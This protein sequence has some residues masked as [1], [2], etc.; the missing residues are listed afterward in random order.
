MLKGLSKPIK[1][2]SFEFTPEHTNSTIECIKLLSK[3]G[4]PNFNYILGEETSFILSKWVSA[5]EIINIIHEIQINNKTVN[6]DIY[7]RF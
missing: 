2:L 3:L 5:S 4:I 7:V 6:G 1:F